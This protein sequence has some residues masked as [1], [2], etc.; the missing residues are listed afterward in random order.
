LFNTPTKVAFRAR[1]FT[2]AELVCKTDK[3][4][5][6]AKFEGTEGTLRIHSKGYDCEPAS[7]K[8]WK[9][10]ANATRLYVSENHYRNFID[11][12]KSRKEPIEP[13]E[14]GHRTA[15]LCHLG[16]LAMILKRRLQ[17][18]PAKEQ[19]VGDEEANKMLSRPLRAPW[20]YA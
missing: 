18:D 5:F 16:N 14:A 8:D 17:W 3:A 9:P 6:G 15:S 1:Y 10:G 11:C 12:V 13:V 4:T 7:L 19:V 20:S 2:G